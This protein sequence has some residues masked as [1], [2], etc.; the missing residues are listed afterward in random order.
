VDGV[1]REVVVVA[2]LAVASCYHPT[3]ATDVPCSAM[4]ECPNGQMCDFGRSPPTCVGVISDGR[5][6]DH[7]IDQP[8]DAPPQCTDNASCAANA[9][10]CD[11][12]VGQCRGCTADAE[13]AT[14]SGGACT[15]YNGQC[16]AD[17][18]TIY[19]I[20]T[21]G[22]D[23]GTCPSSAPCA[24]I[25]YALSQVLGT[26]RTIQIGDGAYPGVPG[27]PAAS[28]NITGGRVV[29]SGIRQ[30]YVGGAVLS[31]MTDGVTNP[32]V[33]QISASNDIV[34]EGLTVIN[35][36]NDGIRSSGALLLS[37]VDI[38][39]NGNRGLNAPISN[40]AQTHIWSSR[41]VGNGNE[42][43][44]LQNGSL[45]ILRSRIIGNTGGGVFMRSGA[46]T[47]VSTIVANNGGNG[48]NIGGVQLQSLGGNAPTIAF[49]TIANNGTKQQ[50]NSPGFQSDA[51]ATLEISNSI[52]CNNTAQNVTT[53]PQICSSCSATYTLFS[54]TPPIG[55]GNLTGAPGFVDVIGNDLHI[56]ASSAAHG[57]ADANA[58]V[59]LD[60]DN[61]TRPQGAFDMGAD[62]IP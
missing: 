35:G 5:L 7:A 41:I 1:R 56:T 11:L 45:E 62:E 57:A 21:G 49:D 60:V 28:F 50:S 20:A 42:G 40:Q 36:G 29:I 47:L 61:E 33:V 22:A 39:N 2:A 10:I 16:V 17:A 8:T 37:Y 9:P 31:A 48:T 43:I 3:I 53:P 54:G 52:V 51:T 44:N 13:C 46:F 23:T 27:S 58:T 30:P 19:L 59:H 25:G 18:D 24:T 4:G 34:L 32:V 55:T 38:E 6:A 14:I 15:E 12:S 26:R